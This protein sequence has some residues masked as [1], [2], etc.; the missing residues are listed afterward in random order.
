MRN[1]YWLAAAVAAFVLAAGV[2]AQAQEPAPPSPVDVKDNGVETPEAPPDAPGTEAKKE[3]ATQGARGR[4]KGIFGG[5]YMLLIIVGGFFLLYMWMGRGRKKR[6]QK[7]REMIESLKKG[8]KITTIG[9]IVGTVV[10]VRDDEVMVKV[11]E[12]NNVRMKFARWSIRGIGEAGKAENPDQAE[13][14]R[15]S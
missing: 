7:R 10:E 3:P 6:Q 11:D 2:W 14:G 9:G 15:K 1:A 13:R 12:N 5:Q 4:G 8:D